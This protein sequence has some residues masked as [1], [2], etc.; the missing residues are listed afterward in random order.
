TPFGGTA[1]QLPGTVQAENFD[2]GGPGIAYFDTTAGNAGNLYRTT[3]VDLETSTDIGGGYDVMKTRAGEWL[4]YTVD[5][6]TA[7]TYPLAIRIANI[8]IGGT[9]QSEVDGVDKTGAIAVPDT[10]GWQAWQTITTPPIVFTAG[11]HV[12]RVSLDTVG[13]GGGIGNFN[14]FRVGP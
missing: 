5:V 8:G 12:L 6:V 14:W 9:F 10:G 13:T 1:V 3:D 2:E 7:G 4:K 11:R